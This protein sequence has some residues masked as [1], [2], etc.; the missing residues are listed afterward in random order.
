MQVGDVDIIRCRLVL[1]VIGRTILRVVCV[2]IKLTRD[3]AST[4][5]NVTM[6]KAPSPPPTPIDRE[7]S[8]LAGT[9]ARYYNQY[10]P[11]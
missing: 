7:K 11:S 9:L 8:I 4:S 10:I 1:L 2:K 5:Q 3:I 6:M